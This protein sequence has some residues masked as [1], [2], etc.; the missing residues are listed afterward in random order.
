MELEKLFL[1]KEEIPIL[2]YRCFQIPIHPK[3]LDPNIQL[4]PR[5]A[6]EIFPKVAEEWQDELKNKFPSGWGDNIQTLD[7]GFVCGFSISR[8]YGG[9]L[10]FD[11]SDSNCTSLIPT[12]MINFSQDKVKE[13]ENKNKKIWTY[14]PHNIDYFPG[15]L[16]LRNWVIKYMNEVLQELL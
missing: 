3:L 10:Y 6:K 11:K 7:N 8:D 13:F 14:A 2:H 4:N 9:T 15:A 5:I 16:F 12:K 1:T